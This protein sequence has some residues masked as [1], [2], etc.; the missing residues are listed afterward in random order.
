[1]LDTYRRLMMMIFVTANGK[2]ISRVYCHMRT[3]ICAQTVTLLPPGDLFI[4]F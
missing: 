1:M 2:Q 4:Y 3:V